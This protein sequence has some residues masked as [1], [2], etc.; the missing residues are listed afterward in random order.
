MPS[1]GIKLD[2]SK[3]RF[4][5]RADE[6]KQ[7]QNIYKEVHQNETTSLLLVGGYSGTGKSLLVETF[8]D[9]LQQRA[10]GE[11]GFYFISGKYE[12]NSM[13]MEPFL[14]LKQAFADLCT[15]LE[16]HRKD[17]DAVGTQLQKTLGKDGIVVLARVIP[18]L[19]DLL[20]ISSDASIEELDDGG[21]TLQ[22]M[23]H[24]FRVFVKSIISATSKTLI[25]SIDGT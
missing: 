8:R 17:A 24:V 15:Q 7:I 4:V 5:G 11:K 12:Q 18:G 23:L 2:L 19:Y 21:S 16:F 1:L 20:E 14:G 3:V 9:R 13:M 6:I 10:S 25:I 22:R